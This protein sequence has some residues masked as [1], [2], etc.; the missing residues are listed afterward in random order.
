MISIFWMMSS[1]AGSTGGTKTGT[2]K[3]FKKLSGR[4]TQ[5]GTRYTGKPPA[6]R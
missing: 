3:G 1:E 2:L 6:I 5:N 4:S